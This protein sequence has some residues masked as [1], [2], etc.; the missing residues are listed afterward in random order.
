MAER[1]IED[2]ETDWNKA[3]TKKERMEALRKY[4]EAKYYNAGL[5]EEERLNAPSVF[6]KFFNAIYKVKAMFGKKTKKAISEQQKQ[7]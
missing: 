4:Q 1:K 5:R 7:H 6:D 3:K 2:W